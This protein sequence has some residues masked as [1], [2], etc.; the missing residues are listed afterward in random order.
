MHEAIVGHCLDT[1]VEQDS[2][3]EPRKMPEVE[4]LRI[5]RTSRQQLP[6]MRIPILF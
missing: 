2:Y 1:R 5:I 4:V 3:E 6:V